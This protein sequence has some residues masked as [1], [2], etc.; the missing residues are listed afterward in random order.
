M[1]K[2][3]WVFDIFRFTEVWEELQK[4]IKQGIDPNTHKPV[5]ESRDLILQPKGLPNLA[6]SD[7]IG[8]EFWPNNI[9][10]Y[11]SGQKEYDPLFFS[12]FQESSDPIGYHS[13]FVTDH[14]HQINQIVGNPNSNLLHGLTSMPDLANFNAGNFMSHRSF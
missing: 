14:D 10:C 11:N 1:N 7:E 6:N 5:P 3:L 12:E 8:Q 13:N 2:I 9:I 4:L